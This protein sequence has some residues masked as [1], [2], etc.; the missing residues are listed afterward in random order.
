MASRWKLLRKC[1]RNHKWFED[2]E[3][4][5]LACA[6]DSGH[7]PHQTDDGILWL[8][9]ERPIIIGEQDGRIWISTPVIKARTDECCA[10]IS[11]LAE[12][13]YLTQEHGMEIEVHAANG[14][15]ARLP[16]LQGAIHL[17]A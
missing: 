14:L 13:I 3:S 5:R 6:D 15:K 2:M 8:N 1:Y 12:M 9:R 16:V 17:G 11:G 10:I 4:G 7:Y